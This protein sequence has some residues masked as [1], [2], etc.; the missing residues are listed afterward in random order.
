MLRYF[1]DADDAIT[2]LSPLFSDAFRY[3]AATTCH[4]RHYAIFAL[5][6]FSRCRRRYYG[7]IDATPPLPRA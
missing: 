3:F 1:H 5:R 7:Y 4:C 2:A 6:F